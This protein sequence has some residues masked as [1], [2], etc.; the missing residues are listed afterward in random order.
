MALLRT[1]LL[2]FSLI[3]LGLKYGYCQG[4]LRFADPNEHSFTMPFTLS[5]NLIIL[6]VRINGSVPLNFVL[7]SG[8]ASTIITE[9]TGV[10]TLALRYVRELTLAGLGS[11]QPGRAYAS[12]GNTLSL[13]YP[14]NNGPA[15]LG[16]NM[17]VYV[18]AEDHFNLS[19]QLGLQVNGLIGSDFF[20]SFVIEISYSERLIRFHHP[21][22]FIPGRK[23]RKY[24]EI[25]VE[26]H[27]SKALVSGTLFQEEAPPV[28][29]RL[30]LDTGAS[31]S[32]WIATHS[33]SRIKTPKETIPALLG[34]GL[35]GPIGGIN[36]RVPKFQFGTHSFTE[37]VVSFP[38]SSSV[39][40]LME[41]MDRNGS[42]GN[43]I[44]R[45]FY[46]VYDFPHNRLL[47]RPNKEI[48]DPFSFNLS[49]MEIEKPYVNLPAYTV[50]SIIPGSPA[51]I[52]GVETGDLLLMINH[53]LTRNLKIDDINSFLHGHKGNKIMLRLDRNGKS[54]KVRFRL[55]EKI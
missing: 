17:D 21:D 52:A 41:G 5:Q 49:G 4:S 46:V 22:H 48:N 28:N 14:S 24:Q 30:L 51:D 32:M 13:G 33:D 16:E 31:L 37:L 18:L 29:V 47:I 2:L 12:T 36:G 54:L 10:D 27:G 9:L 26:L 50:F 20:T 19:K 3:F 35:N 25:P 15:I 40:G 38:D 1:S 44:L 39:V 8:L 11:G 6:P 55:H 23:F 34:Q 45:R 53:Q 7:D 43:D 42:L